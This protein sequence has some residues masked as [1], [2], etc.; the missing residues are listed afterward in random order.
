MR[1]LTIGYEGVALGEFL[2]VLQ[3]HGVRRV[4]DVRDIPLSRKRGFSKGALSRA[5]EEVGIEYVHERVLGT[6]KPIRQALKDSG[7]WSQ[8]ERSYM[9]FLAPRESNFERILEF[10]DLCLLCFEANWLECHRSLVVRR[11][12]ELG[13]VDEVRHLEP[14]KQTAIPSRA[15]AAQGVY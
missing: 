3:A 5:L 8:Y 6:P 10:D 9:E 13:L 14:T 4:V 15:L 1:V 7:D 11:M 12:S 2:D